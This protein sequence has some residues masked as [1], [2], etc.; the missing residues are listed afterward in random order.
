MLR[1]MEGGRRIEVARRIVRQ[2]LDERVPSDVPVALRAFGHTEPHSCA[3][4]LLV[5]PTPGNHDKVRQT[6]DDIRAINLARTPL[7]VSLASVKDDLDEFG[8][9]PRLVVML[10]D[11]EETCEGDLDAAVEALVEEGIDVR[12][13]I[14]GDR[15]S[16]RLNSSH[17]R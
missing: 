1:A 16:T 2:V 9:Q 12:L 14:V 11:G 7:A 4:E 17:V 8:D 13:N 6:V 15:K 10:T 5:A 3:T